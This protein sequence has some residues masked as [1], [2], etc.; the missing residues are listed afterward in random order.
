MLCGSGEMRRWCWFALVFIVELLILGMVGFATWSRLEPF[1]APQYSGIDY[2]RMLAVTNAFRRVLERPPSEAELIEFENKLSSDPEFDV[3]ALETHLRQSPEYK[4]LVNLQ[5]NS[6]NVSMEGGL[7]SEHAIRGKL[8]DMYQRIT[9]QKVDTVTMDLLY[10]RYRHTNLSDAYITALIQQMASTGTVANGSARGDLSAR[11]GGAFDDGSRSG[12]RSGAPL[13]SGDAL[14][15][16]K[17]W[18]RSLG[19]SERDLAGDP[20]R[21]LARIREV[22]MRG[23]G[24]EQDVANKTWPTRRGS[25]SE[26]D[27]K[28][29]R[30]MCGL[31][32]LE[33][34]RTLQSI[35]YEEG[36]PMGSWT[37][38]RNKDDRSLGL[39]R[40]DYLDLRDNDP[41]RTPWAGTGAP[42]SSGSVS[43]GDVGGNT[44]GAELKTSVGGKASE[45]SN[46]VA[47]A[48]IAQRYEAAAAAE[49][50]AAEKRAL[51]LA[52]LEPSART[53]GESGEP[54]AK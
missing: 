51:E 36:A 41:G 38:P 18:L 45:F 12:K 26:C 15:V 43:A 22:A 23:S 11:I 5:S 42:D 33:R 32:S 4:R 25:A 35:R 46:V 48:D 47:E 31:K 1:E 52:K 20:Q 44:V 39:A 37:L 13:E 2:E 49:K 17:K 19:L 50:A 28:I 29:T 34:S 16:E 9:G 40:M 3:P 7:V 21:V 14:T 53:T 6:F 24:G 10:S 27:K 8:A 54:A 30:A